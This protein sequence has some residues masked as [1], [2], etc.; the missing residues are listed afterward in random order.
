[1]EEGLSWIGGGFVVVVRS[2]GPSS[3]AL[4]G[5]RRLENGAPN[6]IKDSSAAAIEQKPSS[7]AAR[8]AFESRTLCG[9][10]TTEML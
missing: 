10:R 2:D 6:A 3:D 8:I 9:C 4:A 1:M 5:S 7:A